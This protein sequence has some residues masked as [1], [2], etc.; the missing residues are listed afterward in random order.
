M[1]IR[2]VFLNNNENKII[3]T[4]NYMNEKESFKEITDNELKEMNVLP[5][6][7]VFIDLQKDDYKDYINSLIKE[8]IINSEILND[9][10]RKES[11][12]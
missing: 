5:D 8:K 11:N 4:R 6:E 7:N 12:L 2:S 3:A 1:D 10:L 9:Y